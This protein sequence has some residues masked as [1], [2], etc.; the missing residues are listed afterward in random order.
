MIHCNANGGDCK[1]PIMND[2]SYGFCQTHY[3]VVCRRPHQPPIAH[4]GWGGNKPQCFAPRKKPTN[5]CEEHWGQWE[6]DPSSVAPGTC[7]IGH[8][9][10]KGKVE[11]HSNR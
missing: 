10:E 6:L 8:I 5:L 1:A 7:V 11:I 3:D 9:V 2:Y 4:C